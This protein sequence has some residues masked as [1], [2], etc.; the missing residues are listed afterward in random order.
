MGYDETLRDFKEFLST[1]GELDMVRWLGLDF[2]EGEMKRPWEAYDKAVLIKSFP[3]LEKIYVVLGLKRRLR[4]R[5]RGFEDV[6]AVSEKGLTLRERETVFVKPKEPAQEIIRV[7]TEFQNTFARE[8]SL[9]RENS[10]GQMAD[11]LPYALPAVEVVARR[12]EGG[13]G[14]DEV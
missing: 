13:T 10:F 1:P 6:V 5:P 3:N 11:C 12:V 14:Y 2:V 9:S 7:R 8:D 4:A